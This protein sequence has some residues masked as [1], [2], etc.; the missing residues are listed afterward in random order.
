MNAV[1]PFENEHVLL[2]DHTGVIEPAIILKVWSGSCVNL[3][4]YHGKSTSPNEITSIQHASA[5]GMTKDHRFWF[6][7]SELEEVQKFLS[8]PE[9]LHSS[10]ET[11]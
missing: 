1:T 11:M 8:A 6:Y 2:H 4:V 5:L 7:L 3:N 9:S 10:T